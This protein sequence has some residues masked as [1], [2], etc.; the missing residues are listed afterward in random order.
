MLIRGRPR[1]PN[2]ELVTGLLFFNGGVEIGQVLFTTLV[3]IGMPLLGR[4]A[5]SRGSDDRLGQRLQAKI[6]D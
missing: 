5:W 6:G 4:V 3:V 2:T 1:G